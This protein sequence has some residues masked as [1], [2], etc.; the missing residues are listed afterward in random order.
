[1]TWN[2]WHKVKTSTKTQ[3]Q[4]TGSNKDSLKFNNEERRQEL[5][6]LSW[7]NLPKRL[8]PLQNS[9]T[10]HY[11]KENNLSNNLSIMRTEHMPGQ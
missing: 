7:V 11:N 10:V 9:S 8:N 5:T 3:D 6:T 2:K 4:S 1:M